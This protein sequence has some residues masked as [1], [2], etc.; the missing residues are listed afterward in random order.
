MSE[1]NVEVIK[2]EKIIPHENA[3]KLEIVKVDEYPVIVRKGEFKPGDTGIYIP[4]D[5]M[6]KTTREEFSFLKSEKRYIERIKAKKLRGIFSMGLIIPN[7]HNWELGKNVQKELEIDKWEPTISTHLGGQ[8]DIDY[9]IFSYY[10]LEGL[11]KY[12]DI[13]PIGTEVVLTEKIHGTNFSILYSTKHNKIIVKSHKIYKKE[14]NDC[15][16]WRTI[17]KYKLDEAVKEFPDIGFQ[18]EIYGWV[19]KLRYGTSWGERKLR[20]FDA[21]NVKDKRY[22]SFRTFQS[23]VEELNNYLVNRYKKMET[24]IQH[25]PIIKIMPY[26]GFDEIKQF[27]EGKTL[28][29]SESGNAKHIREGFVIQPM[30]EMWNPKVG[31][32]KLKYPGEGYLLGVK[33]AQK[34]M[35]RKRS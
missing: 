25:V 26:P 7:K 5:S 24:T 28:L 2:I 18:G 8:Q 33:D 9:G 4:I 6:I 23:Y 19:Q 22:F 34:K 1:F 30:N 14:V 21:I 12:P 3:D 32:V 13:I 27:G 31:R 16:W 15:L 17:K 10:D 29:I 11:R 20:L 35:H